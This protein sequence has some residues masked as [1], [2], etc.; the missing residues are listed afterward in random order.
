[1]FSTDNQI[2]VSPFVHSFDTT[3][4][5]AAELVEPKICISSKELKEHS[6][7]I[8]VKFKNVVCKLFQFERV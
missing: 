1:M 8:F 5:F 4:L 3:S 6:L 2:I 7:P